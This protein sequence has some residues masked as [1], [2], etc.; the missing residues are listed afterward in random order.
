MVGALFN[1]YSVAR[2]GSLKEPLIFLLLSVIAWMVKHTILS[3]WVIIPFAIFLILIKKNYNRFKQQKYFQRI[4]KFKID[5]HFI[6]RLRQQYPRLNTLQ[7]QLIEAGLKDYFVLHAQGTESLAMPSHAVDSL[8][9]ILLDYPSSY[10]TFCREIVGHTV[11]HYPYES[12][13][14]DDNDQLKLKREIQLMRTWQKACD[15]AGESALCPQKMPRLMMI[16]QV[17]G[18]DNP[19]CYDMG[20]MARRYCRFVMKGSAA[21]AVTIT[22]EEYFSADGSSDGDSGADGGGDSGCG[23]GCGGGCGS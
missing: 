2:G 20:D 10:E 15:L 13:D 14:A 4:E 22:A 1:E 7:C 8:W 21:L 16:D 9:H 18:W 11:H 3:F 6:Q 12:N 19:Q 5:D 17:L 23:G